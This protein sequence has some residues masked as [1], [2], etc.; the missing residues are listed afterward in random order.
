MYLFQAAFETS[1]S[2]HLKLFWDTKFLEKDKSLKDT[3]SEAIS[4]TITEP[5]FA[6]F[7]GVPLVKSQREYQ[8][9]LLMDTGYTLMTFDLAFPVAKN[10]PLK[11]VL[12]Y[13][14]VQLKE[15]GEWDRIK[16]K[17]LVQE[18]KCGPSKGSSL[19]F[20]RLSLA[21]TVILVGFLSAGIMLVCEVLKNIIHKQQKQ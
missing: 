5:N 8:Q 7:E 6:L 15:H 9:C 12:N 17:Y 11:D 13:A 4:V 10:S 2:G 14:L 1:R 16:R 20:D 19:G 21:F 18:P 3:L